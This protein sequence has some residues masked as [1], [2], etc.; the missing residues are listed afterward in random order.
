MI[1]ATTMSRILAGATAIVLSVTALPAYASSLAEVNGRIIAAPA[2]APIEMTSCSMRLASVAGL[3]HVGIRNRNALHALTYEKIRFRGYDERGLLLGDKTIEWVDSN[4]PSGQTG[5]FRLGNTGDVVAYDGF[6]STASM[7]CEVVAAG[8]DD[9][10]SWSPGVVWTS[11][12]VTAGDVVDADPLS[13]T[14]AE[15]N[16]ITIA[17]LGTWITPV[18]GGKGGKERYAHVRVQLAAST[19]PIVVRSHDFVLAAA[20]KNG[21]IAH[22]RGLDAAAPLV[23]VIDNETGRSKMEP[24]VIS[25]EDLGA[26]GDATLTPSHP[27]T[28]VITYRLPDAAPTSEPFQG[29]EYVSDVATAA[30]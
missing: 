15:A 9:H 6:E 25:S 13:A 24:A 10:T 23:D 19:A 8:F 18:A 17:V 12:I 3:P 28:V 22:I 2:G 30:R 11:K 14:A 7:T 20:F 27:Q 4:V 1:E 16:P 26:I 5:S 21:T 29:I